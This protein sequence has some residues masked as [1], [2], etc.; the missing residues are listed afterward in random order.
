L[1]CFTPS[2]Q[3]RGK[4][5]GDLVTTDGLVGSEMP[6]SI[7]WSAGISNASGN[8]SKLVEDGRIRD[9]VFVYLF[10]DKETM[11]TIILLE[12]RDG[13][14]LISMHDCGLGCRTLIVT[15]VLQP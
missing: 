3:I 9:R 8:N 11:L 2:E 15:F 5:N 13:I 7:L 1:D 14:K 6:I 12:M 4:V 10:K